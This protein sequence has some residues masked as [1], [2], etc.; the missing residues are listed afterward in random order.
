M[1]EANW[2]DAKRMCA[3][4]RG[5]GYDDWYL[6]NR[7]EL[8][9]IYVNLRRKGKITGDTWYWSSSFYSTDSAWGQD[10][11]NGRQVDV[12]RNYAHSVR[13]VRAFNTSAL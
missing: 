7:E 12:Y 11:G 3:K 8:N 1:G 5:G 6:P 13:A 10:F 2:E 9:W 4:Y